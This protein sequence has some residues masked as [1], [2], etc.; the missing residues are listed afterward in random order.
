MPKIMKT[1]HIITILFVLMVSANSCEKGFVELNTNK[2]LP[3]SLNPNYQLADACRQGV[4][5]GYS[6][7]IIQHMQTLIGGQSEGGNRNILNDANSSGFFNNTFSN[8]IAS[9][10]DII[11][12]YKNDPNFVNV[13]SAARIYKA[14]I[15]QL[16]VDVYGDVPYTEAGLGYLENNFHP[17]YDNQEDIYTDLVKELTEATSLLDPDN[18][19]LTG[20]VF[21]NGDLGKW[22]K[23][24]NSVLLRIGM[25][26][27]KIDEAKAKDIV[28]TAVD[29]S[30]GGVISSNDDNVIVKFN[31]IFTTN[32]TYNGSTRQDHFVGE[33]LVDF[34]K[35]NNDPRCQYLVCLYPHPGLI[36]RGTPNT[37]PEDQIGCPF[38]Y[39]DGTVVNDPN[40]PGKV[41]GV[42]AYSQFNGETVVRVNSWQYLVTYSHTQLLLAEARHRGYIT[43]GTVKDYYEQGIKANMTQVDMY[44]SEP[45]GISPITTAEQDA[46]LLEPEIAFDPE[47]ALEQIN[48]QYWVSCILNTTEGW[49]NFRRSGYPALS[50]MDFPG[51]DPSVDEDTGGD[52]FI[53][54][55]PYPSREKEVNSDNV[56]AAITRMGGDNFGI[57]LFWDPK[58]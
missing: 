23:F 48:T 3:T 26:Y 47:R 28:T 15:M 46:Y 35:N 49:A 6:V 9:L 11:E 29:P 17:K 37:N 5:D 33:P 54:R 36:D 18:D 22:K 39:T 21:F 42:F 24:A 8:R 40:F 1:K 52:G 19:E 58:L 55:L 43:T 57:R 50:P 53:H 12:R 20:D 41:E 27:T 30:R 10:I 14:F 45:G 31:A 44:V 51:E 32:G 56:Q 7:H 16:L 13:V 2:Y 25:R 34:L 38:G 4:G